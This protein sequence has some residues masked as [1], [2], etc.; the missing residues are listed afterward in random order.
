MEF[1]SDG[2]RHGGPWFI[3]GDKSIGNVKLGAVGHRVDEP[4]VAGAKSVAKFLD[5]RGGNQQGT[6]KSEFVV[7]GGREF[8]R[9]PA[10][11]GLVDEGQ[12]IC[13]G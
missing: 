9:V 3:T 10:G 7:T 11:T 5:T 2:L 4:L 13:Y 12:G 6:H 8:P 1:G